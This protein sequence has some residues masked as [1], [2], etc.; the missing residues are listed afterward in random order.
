MRKAARL[1]PGE[2]CT[3][4]GADGLHLLFRPNAVAGV[5]CRPRPRAACGTGI[6]VFFG[7]QGARDQ[8]R[9]SR[10]SGQTPPL[11]ALLYLPSYSP[12]LNLIE[13]FWKSVKRTALNAKYYA[14]FGAIKAAVIGCVGDAPAKNKRELDSLFTRRFQR[15]KKP[16][17]QAA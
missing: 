8:V 17:S 5:D 15:F 4:L 14:G 12:N 9:V 7:Q 10:G 3:A 6:D 1:L 13:A 11:R 2:A 16:Q